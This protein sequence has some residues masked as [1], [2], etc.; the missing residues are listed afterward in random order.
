MRQFTHEPGL[1]NAV[2]YCDGRKVADILVDEAGEWA[3]RPGHFVWIGLYEPEAD[4]LARVQKQF[5]LHPLAIEDAEQAHQHPLIEEYGNTLFVVAQTAQM[6]DG[7]IAFGETHLFI[8][9]GYVV[10]VRH[11]ASSSYASVR[12]RCEAAPELL[13]H[14]EIYILYAILKFVV[15]NYVP[16]LD[17]I[18]D[19]A[20]S[21]E[22]RVLVRALNAQ[23][24]NR[25]YL[26]RRDLL[27]LRNAAVPLVAICRHI[28]HSNVLAIAPPMRPYFRDVT[29]HIRRVLS[30]IDTLRE[31]L[32][33]A[34]E[35]GEMAGEMQ[36]T[37]ITRMLAAWAAI[38]AV[39]TLV[40]GIYG[41]NFKHMPELDWE[42]GYFVVMGGMAA[43]SISLY[44][45]FRRV[46]WL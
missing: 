4:L 9:R 20:Q 45:W 39:P 12:D 13:G 19:E 36:Q 31:T 14:G 38:I 25:L 30:E 11:A 15:D 6:V 8:G 43:I 28:A 42:Y 35:A 33:F 17:S 21:L 34:F 46:G 7:R 24:I 10:S 23:E 5:D 41:M 22:D 16:V 27:K 40:A 3:R 2:A 37:V 1:V 18:T 44:V 26:L 32:A 29:N